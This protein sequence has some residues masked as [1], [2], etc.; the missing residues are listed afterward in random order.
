MLAGFNSAFDRPMILF[1]AAWCFWVLWKKGAL[2]G[3][4]MA[5][6]TLGLHQRLQQ[7]LGLFV[8]ASCS[9]E[10]RS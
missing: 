8:A 7:A 4:L 3:H 6:G 2:L 5:L 10:C 9:E 1:L